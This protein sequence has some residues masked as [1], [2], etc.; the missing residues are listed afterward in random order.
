MDHAAEAGKAPPDV[1]GILRGYRNSLLET[2]RDV[3]VAAP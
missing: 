1:A 3:L 2:E